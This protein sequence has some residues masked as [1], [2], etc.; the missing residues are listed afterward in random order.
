[1][2]TLI[3]SLVLALFTACVPESDQTTLA[4]PAPTPA[5][6]L[7]PTITSAP[8][9]TPTTAPTAIPKPV[10]VLQPSFPIPTDY[11]LYLRDVGMT[12]E[13]RA[14]S[15]DGSDNRLVMSG[16]HLT[17]MGMAATDRYLAFSALRPYVLDLQTGE[18]TLL[19][20]REES[21]IASFYWVSDEV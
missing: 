9:H 12:V 17:N 18:I 1:M 14:V 21:A 6:T 13:V 2:R 16:E 4:T 20:P 11:I 19:D 15:P 8:S 7:A 3:V 5:Y 10:V